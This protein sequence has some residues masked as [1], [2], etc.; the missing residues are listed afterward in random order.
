MGKLKS[1]RYF[2]ETKNYFKTKHISAKTF[3]NYVKNKVT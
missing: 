3:A 2:T 1:R